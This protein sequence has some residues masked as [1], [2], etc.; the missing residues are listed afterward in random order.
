MSTAPAARAFCRRDLG[1]GLGLSGIFS[2]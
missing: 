1:A 2:W